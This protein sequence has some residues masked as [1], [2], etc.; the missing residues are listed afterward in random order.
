MFTVVIINNYPQLGLKAGEHYIAMMKK[1]AC[2]TIWK[3]EKWLDI[4]ADW[5]SF[6]GK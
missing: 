1:T 3:N 2:Y 4:N 5:A 6:L